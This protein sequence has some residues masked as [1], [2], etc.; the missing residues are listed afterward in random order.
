MNNKQLAEM[1]KRLRKE[2]NDSMTD[3][4]TTSHMK[5]ASHDVSEELLK[6]YPSRA[7]A[8]HPYKG[9][10]GNLPKRYGYRKQVDITKAGPGLQNKYKMDSVS[11]NKE[12]VTKTATNSKKNRDTINT[13]P[14]Q[15][16]AM[17]GTQ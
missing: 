12:E 17:I 8:T 5:G 10:L 16:S 4:N 1:I 6:E 7:K 14:E 2:R 3:M 9:N 11:E 13:K 15:D